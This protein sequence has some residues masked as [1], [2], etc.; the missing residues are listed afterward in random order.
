MLKKINLLLVIITISII[1]T[2]CTKN[3]E[4]YPVII[5]DNQETKEIKA[6]TNEIKIETTEVNKASTPKE[7]TLDNVSPLWEIL[8]IIPLFVSNWL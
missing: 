7:N 8:Q 2:G 5:D 4:K 1:S 3:N 6:D